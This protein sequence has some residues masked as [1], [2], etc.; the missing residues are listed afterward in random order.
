MT[1]NH[2]APGDARSPLACAALLGD[3]DTII[4]GIGRVTTEWS[5]HVRDITE[6]LRGTQSSRVRDTAALALVD[7]GAKTAGD[8]IVDVLRRPDIARHAGTLL[9]ALD[10]LAASI[11][12]DLA[13]SLIENGSYEARAETILFLKDGR[14]ENFDTA[15]R[16]GARRRL[17]ALVT[18]QDPELR[19]AAAIGLDILGR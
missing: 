10:E 6:I 14:I 17:S 15:D 5:S 8:S 3:E 1:V 7:M 13:V 9:Y 12:L 4:D 19:E 16:I 11:P 2:A 18:S